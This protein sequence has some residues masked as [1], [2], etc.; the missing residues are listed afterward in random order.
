M[1]SDGSV[2]LASGGFSRRRKRMLLLAPVLGA[3]L[4]LVMSRRFGEPPAAPEPA[5]PKRARPSAA[6][7]E[8][9][10]LREAAPES[11]IDFR[12]SFLPQEQGEA[13]KV[14][15]YDHGSGLA[16]AD[17]DG[18]GDEDLLFLNQL[19]TNGLYR[20]LGDGQF[21]NATA[22]AG[23]VGLGDRVCVGAAFGDY[24][25]D[26]DQDLYITS[27]RGG[28]VLFQN[29]GGGRYREVTEEAGV[30]LVA[31]SQ[32]PAFFDYDNDGYLD[33][34]VTNTARWTTDNFDE[35]ARY[36]RGA[37]DLWTH[38]YRM[39]DR[40]SNVLFHNNRDGTFSDVTA[41]AGLAGNGW[42][43]DVAAFDFDD[44]GHLDLLV[45]NMFGMSQLYR[46]DGHGHFADVAAEALRRT[47]LGAI[48]C[49]AFDYNNDGRMDLFIADM[50][51]DMWLG[52]R[53]AH[54]VQPRKKFGHLFGPA[55]EVY[56]DKLVNE[57][58]LAER[59]Q[60]D[61][62]K[63][64]FGNSLFR[65][66][67]AGRFAEVSDPA[68]METFWPW[69]VAVGDFDNDGDEDAFL[70]SGM[71]YPYFY[72]PSALMLNNG[73]GTFTDRAAEE[74][75]EP[76]REGQFLAERIG[77]NQ[78]ARSSR[79]TATADFDGDGRLDLVVNNFNDRPYY[80]RNEFPSRH[81]VAFRLR[82]TRSNRDA[83]G[84]VAR[85][86]RG[87]RV[88]TRQVPCT[89]G[90]LSQSSKVLHFGLG[91]SDS[92]DRVEIRWPSG[93]RQVLKAPPADRLNKVTE[94]D[95]P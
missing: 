74:G 62:D 89:G 57:S 72:W 19:G 42:S 88:M 58:L 49:K 40:E 12:M 28:N 94:P 92:I 8:L 37:A 90:Y 86:Y 22:D 48:G 71:G 56:P 67:G 17:Y 39:E 25:N 52:Y 64:L 32:T 30:P 47:S 54:L 69:G 27:T 60:L 41:A 59:L 46:N 78:A 81:Y 5:Q 10:G 14:N 84:A 36:Y 50:H 7:H 79:C 29:Q 15:L 76:P 35:E 95:G 55:V 4:W 53:D 23:E 70:P 93:T 83:I 31:H 13:F 2:A 9:P 1:K 51:S 45:T 87:D 61:Y 3:L 77:G 63:L 65:N 38:V 91:D 75:I 68:G 33:L 73:D 16:I 80:F 20:N 82:G 11:G 43:G 26:G 44:D 85:L 24:D 66:D 21:E 6:H 34:F 18:D